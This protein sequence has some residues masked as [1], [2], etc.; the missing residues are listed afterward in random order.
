MDAMTVFATCIAYAVIGN[1]IVLVVLLRR[2]TPLRTMRGGTPLYLYGVCSS[3]PNH[4]AL[5]A[6]ALSTNVALLIGISALIWFETG[7]T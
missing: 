5:T 4:R 7:Q 6:F 2:K 3:L 1:A